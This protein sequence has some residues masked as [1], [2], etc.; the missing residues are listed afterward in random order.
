MYSKRWNATI[1]LLFVLQ[2]LR[3]F[4]P[5]CIFATFSLYTS[6]HFCISICLNSHSTMSLFSTTLF[7]C[8]LRDGQD[9]VPEQ[10]FYR[11]GS[12]SK[13]RLFFLSFYFVHT[14]SCK[15]V[16]IRIIIGSVNYSF[17]FY[18]EVNFVQG[19]TQHI[20]YTVQ[21]VYFII[22]KKHYLCLLWDEK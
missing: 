11:I 10:S 4:Q 3:Q 7:R 20:N 14:R 5:S 16:H 22:N 2:F 12:V 9:W 8:F 17:L 15:A 13:V 6:M 18:K 1:Y 21:T 19:V